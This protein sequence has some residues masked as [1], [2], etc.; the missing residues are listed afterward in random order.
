M[1]RIL[2]GL[3]ALFGLASAQLQIKH[4]LGTLT[5]NAPAKR[6]VVLE[7]SFLDTL[8]ALG[9]SPVGAAT[10]TQGG[11]RGLPP[12]LKARAAGVAS[13]GS[14]AQPSLEA[15]L[16]LKPEV[17]VAD[18]FVHKDL[19]P[20]LE[21][22]A[23]VLAFQSRRGSFD[24]LNQQVLELGRLVGK[25]ARARQILEDQERLLQKARAF[26]NPKAPPVLLG[27]ATP[28]SFT[29]HSSESFIGSLLE[30]L[31]RKSLAKP[32]NNQTQ[33]ELGLEGLL[34]LN[35][36]TLVF[37][38]A[39]DETP[40]VRGWA[41]NPLWQRLEAVKRGRIY[42]FDRDNWTRG[43][44]PLATRLILAELIDSGLLADRPAAGRYAFKP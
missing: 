37:F 18:A 44:G 4:E 11:D 5:L 35:P 30:R 3:L 13:I 16:A 34:A 39:P 40:I 19:I 33:Y 23:P 6:V 1:K 20:Q 41:K 2:A 25:E 42:E 12:Y 29:V 36:A 24:D 8:L 17:I 7:Y 38:T 14:R 27:V 31:G 32:Q 22:I 21:R 43:R 26:T 9:V 28:S 10:G 15:I